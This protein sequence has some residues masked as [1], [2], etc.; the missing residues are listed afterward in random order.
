MEQVESS[1][2]G[3]LLRALLH[4]HFMAGYTSHVCV[5]T[6]VCDSRQQEG[7]VVAGT[8]PS[9]RSTVCMKGKHS[10]RFD[11][12]FSWTSQILC[13]ALQRLR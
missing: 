5:S 9:E 3:S 7:H 1:P 6:S 13:R 12:M 2:Q 11:S 10:M 4:E 8:R